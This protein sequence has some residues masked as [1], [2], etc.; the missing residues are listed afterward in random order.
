MPLSP[1]REI[2]SFFIGS[3]AYVVDYF[4]KNF[5]TQIDGQNPKR[6]VAP[7]SVDLGSNSRY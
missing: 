6:K 4:D 1:K 2:L 3:L 5:L 7:S